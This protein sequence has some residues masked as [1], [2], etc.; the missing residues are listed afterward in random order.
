MR[1]SDPGPMRYIA[2]ERPTLI[3]LSKQSSEHTNKPSEFNKLLH[4]LMVDEYLWPSVVA[5]S[6]YYCWSNDVANDTNQYLRE[7]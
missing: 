7:N 3:D 6:R 2:S 1:P 4:T 5:V